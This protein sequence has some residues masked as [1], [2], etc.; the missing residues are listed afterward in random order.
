M[1]PNRIPVHVS[2]FGLTSISRGWN[3]KRCQATQIKKREVLRE[4][5]IK[6]QRC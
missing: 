3:A 2:R 5:H 4:R 1:L 6:A